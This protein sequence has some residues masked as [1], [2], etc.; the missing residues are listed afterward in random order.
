MYGIEST[1]YAIRQTE[2]RNAGERGTENGQREYS[3]TEPWW[4]T[5]VGK[6]EE[7]KTGHD[8]SNAQLDTGEQENGNV[9]KRS[10]NGD[11]S[12]RT[13]KM[14][15]GSGLRIADHGTIPCTMYGIR[16]KVI[17]RCGGY[18]VTVYGIRFM[19]HCTEYPPDGGRGKRE[20][21]E[22]KTGNGNA[23][24]RRHGR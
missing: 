17:G 12:D 16:C 15:S 22:R 23:V 6:R 10:A 9:A 7:R 19:V 20:N 11:R 24:K 21:G 3:K 2:P 18:T 14:G 8:T 13:R 5:G 4:I 1:V